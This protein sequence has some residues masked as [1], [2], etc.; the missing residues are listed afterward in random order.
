MVICYALESTDRHNI[1][2]ASTLDVIFILDNFMLNGFFYGQ[3]QY[4][5]KN[6]LLYFNF[7][8]QRNITHVVF[9][10]DLFFQQSIDS[11]KSNC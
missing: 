11:G 2:F 1:V 3:I 7:H 6:V 10:T 4:D 8:N 9:L 5:T